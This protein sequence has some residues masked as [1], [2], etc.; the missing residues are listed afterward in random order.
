[1][2]SSVASGRSVGSNNG[3]HSAPIPKSPPLKKPQAVSYE[4]YA[5]RSS[6]QLSRLSR[7][8]AL[9]AGPTSTAQQASETPPR[10]STSLLVQALS[11]APLGPSSR[12]AKNNVWEDQESGSSA[13]GSSRMMGQKEVEQMTDQLTASLKHAASTRLAL[14]AS[15]HI[16]NDVNQRHSDLLLHSSE[17]SAAAERLQS[18]AESLKQH[19]ADIGL[20]LQHYNAVDRIGILVGVLFK[21]NK[22]NKLTTVRGLAKLKVDCTEDFCEALDELDDAL[23][24]FGRESGGQAALEA[25]QKQPQQVHSGS[26]EY[27]RRAGVLREAAMDLVREAVADRIRQTTADIC[28]ALKLPKT[29]IAADKLEASLVYTRFHGISS[30]SHVLL[31]IVKK[32]MTS[33]NEDEYTNV[34]QACRTTYC[35][36]RELLLGSTIKAHMDFLRN[37]HGLVGMTRLASVFLMRICTIETA[38]FLDFFGT[39]KNN[40]PPKTTSND[41]ETKEEQGGTKTTTGNQDSTTDEALKDVE[42]QAC[43]ANLC[44]S[45]HRT[46]RRGLVSVHDLDTLCQIVS[47]LRE[48][49]TQAQSSA[50]AA[51]R[52]ISGVIVDA[53]ERL[54][55]CANSALHRQVVQFRPTFADLD[56]PNK[57]LTPSTATTPSSADGDAPM[58]DA[59]EAQLKV[60]ESWFPPMR[61]VL[62]ILSKIFRVVEPR[63]FED[64]ALQ[65]VQACTKCLKDGGA[66][67]RNKSGVVHADL[68]LVKHLLILREQLSPFDIQLRA[69][70]R[71]LDFSDAGKAMSRF[72]AN[73][74]RRLFSMSTE[75]ALVTLLREGVS[76]QESSVDSKRDL[77]DALRSA[78]N[79]FIE[80]TATSVAGS[81]LTFVDQCKGCNEKDALPS[82]PF[83]SGPSVK[84]VMKKA[85]EGLEERLQ[86]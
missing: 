53:Q 77:E 60:Y 85:C 49:R 62:K 46:V 45:L 33:I 2:A 37:R 17:L 59:V 69:V 55:F 72:L 48:E 34:Y 80:H 24:F 52:T 35:T 78:C 3:I 41:E 56:Y 27:Y 10:S 21:V 8:A 58:T 25:L 75:N 36:S 7:I 44:G 61:S 50:P 71:Q 76:V 22:E 6:S 15:I 4:P 84:E 68:F 19:A 32:R 74:N 86:S 12:Q 64:I 54:I 39:T 20:P 11:P 16:A 18:E 1:M 40:T 79:D 63:V 38:L 47:V 66:T 13:S 9:T 30:R 73:R 82:Q 57:L 28:S 26:L 83:A 23:K 67:I 5:P 70:E 42:F 43:L 51:A 14:R 29:P 31:S 65:S 81:V